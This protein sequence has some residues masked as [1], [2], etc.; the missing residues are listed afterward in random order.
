MFTDYAKNYLTKEKRLQ[1]LRQVR[2]QETQW[3]RKL[4]KERYFEAKKHVVHQKLFQRKVH[5]YHKSQ[6]ARLNFNYKS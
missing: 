4:T 5:L 3:A 1:R 2:E 6:D